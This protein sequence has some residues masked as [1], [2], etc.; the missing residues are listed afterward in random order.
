MN[1]KNAVQGEIEP[2]KPIEVLEGQ[3]DIIEYLKPEQLEITEY[4][5]LIK[6][7]WNKSK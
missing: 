5:R 4:N 6:I 3:L 2:L 1:D 7:D